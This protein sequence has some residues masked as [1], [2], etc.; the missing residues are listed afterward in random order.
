MKEKLI[1]DFIVESSTGW[2]MAGD[3]GDLQLYNAKLAVDTRK[4]KKGD[5]VNCITFLFSQSLC[6]IYQ[7]V[8]KKVDGFQETAIVEEFPIKLSIDYVEAIKTPPS[9]S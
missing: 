3:W 1:T 7:P 6:Q 8:G 5:V 2:D 4:F 9:K